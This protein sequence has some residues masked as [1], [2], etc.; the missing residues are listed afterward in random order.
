MTQN[1]RGS[2]R[3]TAVEGNPGRL[4]RAEDVGAKR[5]GR[6]DETD[7]DGESLEHVGIC[8]TTQYILGQ[9]TDDDGLWIN[10]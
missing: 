5:A 1:T 6:M 10:K 2:S 7:R 3:S 8:K 4:Y 9:G